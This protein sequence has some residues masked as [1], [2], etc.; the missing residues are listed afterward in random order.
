M[1]CPQCNVEA[2]KVGAFLVC[3]THGQLPETKPFVPLRIFLS[4]GHDYNEDLVRRIKSDLEER[5]HDVWFDSSEIK[6]GDDWRHSITNGILGSHRVLSFLSKHSTRD[7]GVCRDEIAIAIGVKGGNIQTILVESEKEVQPPV[8]IGHIQWLD[9]HDWKE[10][11]AAGQAEWEQWYQAK[12]AEIVRVVESEESRRFAGEIETLNGHLKPIKSEARICQLLGKGFYGRQWLFEAV[13]KWRS[14]GSAGLRTGPQQ[15]AGSESSA[16]SAPSRLFWIMGAPGVGKSAFAAQLTQTRGDTVIAAQFCEWDKPDHSNAPRVV[17]SLAFQLATRLPDYRKLLLTLPELAELDRKAAAELFD[18]LLANPL[19]SVINGGRERYLIVIDALDEAGEAG[20]NPL[21]EMLARNAPRLPDWLGLVVTSRPEFDVKTPLQALNPF[22]LDTQSE[23]NRADIRDYLRRELASHLQNRPDA[24]RLVEQIL[25]KSEGVF[26]YVERFCD[27]VHRGHLSMDRPEQFP[28]GLGGIFCQYFQRQFP[29]V[30]KFRKEVRPALR[31]ILAAREPLPVEI[32]QCLF[33]W[34]DE[35]LRDFTRQ[36]GSLF[37]TITAA[38]HEIIKPYHKSLADWLADQANA[39]A[40]F[41]SADDGHRMLAEAGWQAF[42]AGGH[43]FHRYFLAHLPRHLLVCGSWSE[44]EL[45]LTDIRFLEAKIAV[46]LTFEIL[47]DFAEAAKLLPAE[48]EQHQ[49]LKPLEEALR[50]DIHFI[51]RHATDYPQA[52]FQ[53]LWNTCWWYDC[54]AAPTHYAP[55]EVGWT[56]AEAPWNHPGPKLSKLLETWAAV[57]Q[58]GRPGSV[59]LRRL[60]PPI[61]H[62]GTAQRAVLVGHTGPV[63]GL[64]L[65]PDGSRLVSGGGRGDWIIHLWDADSGER[66]R[67]LPGHTRGVSSVAFSPDGTRLVSASGDGTVRIWD[68][69]GGIELHCFEVSKN[70]EGKLSD[71]SE[72]VFSPDGRLVASGASD[73]TVRLWNAETGEKLQCLRA[74]EKFIRGVSFSPDG[75]NLYSLGSSELR[76]W[77]V[78]TGRRLGQLAGGC[79]FAVSPD[80]HYL[81]MGEYGGCL[82]VWDIAHKKVLASLS[83]HTDTINSI[84]FAPTSTSRR[85][86]SNLLAST[87]AA[88]DNTTRLWDWKAGRQL[89][90][91]RGHEASA[92]GVVSVILS[93]DGR[94]VISGGDDATIRI[95]DTQEDSLLGRATCHSDD[96]SC[97]AFSCDG[98]LVASGS[99]VDDGTIRIWDSS[100]GLQ[101]LCLDDKHGCVAHLAFLPDNRLVSSGDGSTPRI[102]DL[103]TGILLAVLQ[104]HEESLLGVGGLAVSR[105]GQRIATVGAD[106]TV[107]L[108]DVGEAREILCLRGHT[109]RVASVAWSSSGQWIVSGSDDGTVRVWDAQTGQPLACLNGQEHGLREVAFSL[110]DAQIISRSRNGKTRIWNTQTGGFLREVFTEGDLKSVACAAQFPWRAVRRGGET[111]VESVD[112]GQAIAWYPAGLHSVIVAPSGRLWAGASANHLHLFALIDRTGEQNPSHKR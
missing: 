100:S 107:R 29:D 48:R 53:C 110:D 64:A 54:P 61:V 85:D 14:T 6:F 59:W 55:P 27:D 35:E 46:G 21:V 108:W 73:G 40:Y 32:L 78:V 33:N 68:A 76:I 20:R 38:G 91:Y 74:D 77:D 87:G 31:A 17:R 52:L 81:A 112:T 43:R 28:R 70:S 15:P 71:V 30:E 111:V 3:P 41:V 8:S 12:L 105:D 44:I 2:T 86:T 49:I 56:H 34:Q 13:E 60:Q 93:L 102:W 104:G 57:C 94:S 65:S 22:P 36:L 18:Y 5:G 4:Y 50:R 1:K 51:A 37:P 39:C 79:C 19:R 25:E 7:P 80:N 62:L 47:S 10:R 103:S 63:E 66:L 96:I 101:R 109:Q 26:L 92:A 99:A 67:T 97:L 106:T 58:N 42:E 11:H 84:A 23:S 83:G 45:L 82:K 95:W 75:Q 90:C 98:R 16:P 69:I 24:D 9:M 88:F 89:A 72:A